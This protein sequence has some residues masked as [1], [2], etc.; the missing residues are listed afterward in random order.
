[1]SERPTNAETVKTVLRVVVYSVVAILVAIGVAAAIA[2]ALYLANIGLDYDQIIRLMPRTDAP[3]VA[4]FNR[5]FTAHRALTFLHVV[6]GAAILVLAPFQFSSRLRTRH[7]RFH[8]WS[9]RLV[10]LAALL[11]GLSGLF[12]GAVFPNGSIAASSA[13]FCFGAL[14]LISIVRAF[15]AIRRGNTASHR[16]WM[17]R[18]FSIGI[19]IS[20]IRVVGAALALIIPAS[21]PES[22]IALSFWIGFMLSA[23]AGELWIRN[24]RAGRV[25]HE[26]PAETT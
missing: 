7:I 6:P 23:A 5:W 13:V 2:R 25:A 21:S 15:A 11:A 14:F 8:R 9:G 22:R 1:M 17:I 3:Y 10:L 4:E 12:F 19:G 26:T 16:E 24:T 18:M 20:T